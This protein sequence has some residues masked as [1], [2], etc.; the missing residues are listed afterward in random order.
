MLTDTAIRKIKPE[1]KPIKLA[2]GQCLHLLITPSGGKLWRFR[3]RHAGTENMLA[4][5]AYPHV[6]LAEARELLA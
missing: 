3:Y 1:T 6:T 5:G 4:L 2:D